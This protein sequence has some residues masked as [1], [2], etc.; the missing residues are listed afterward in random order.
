MELYDV[1]YIVMDLE[2]TGFTADQNQIAQ[3]AFVVLNQNMEILDQ[4]CSF[5]QKYDNKILVPATMKFTGITEEQMAE[6]MSADELYSE[7]VSL[8][9]EHKKGRYRKP[10]LVGHNFCSFDLPFIEYIFKRKGDNL[11][12][13]VENFVDDTIFLARKRWGAGEMKDYKLGTCCE[14]AGVL[15]SDAH[16]ALADTVATAQL[17]RYFILTERGSGEVVLMEEAKDHRKKFQF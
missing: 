3:I 15:L 11:Y 4:A 10:I 5:I 17:F 16:E 9:K 1:D 8:F 14:R 6:G 12:N 13:Y 7:L 2:T